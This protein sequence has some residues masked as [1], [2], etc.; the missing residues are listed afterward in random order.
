MHEGKQENRSLPSYAHGTRTWT[1]SV[2]KVLALTLVIGCILLTVI[3]GAAL[4]TIGGLRWLKV[5]SGVSVAA[6][7]SNMANRT[8]HLPGSILG[9][10]GFNPC[11][12]R[13]VLVVAV[14]WSDGE[15]FPAILRSEAAPSNISV[16]FQDFFCRHFRIFLEESRIA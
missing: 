7:P 1:R 8:L 5:A 14:G 15:S 10:V 13:G 4:T 6:G 11:R 9:G 3:A 12:G 2:G 16:P